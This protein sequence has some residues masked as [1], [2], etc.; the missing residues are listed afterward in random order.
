MLQLI[1]SSD[2]KEMNAYAEISIA[3]FNSSAT[4]SL[5]VNLALDNMQYYKTLDYLLTKFNLGHS[6]SAS[7][8]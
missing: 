7:Y 5:C 8:N 6:F 1:E 4:V 3:L 2:K